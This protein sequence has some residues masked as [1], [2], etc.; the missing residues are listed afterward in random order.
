M[1]HVQA[2]KPVASTIH[3]AVYAMFFVKNRFTKLPENPPKYLK[4]EKK[5]L[6]SFPLGPRVNRVNTWGGVV[7]G[8]DEPIAPCPKLIVIEEK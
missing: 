7:G 3:S 1:K 6:Y 4:Y 2:W 5:E 8:L